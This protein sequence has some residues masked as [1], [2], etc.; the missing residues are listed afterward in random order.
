MRR[1]RLAFLVA[2]LSCG[3]LSSSSLP[4]MT[5]A[6]DL[7]GKTLKPAIGV[8][9]GMDSVIGSLLAGALT[10]DV[11]QAV[12]RKDEPTRITVT[13]S[14]TGFQGAKI[15][16]EITASD[17]KTQRQIHGSEPIA[18]QSTPGEVDLSFELDPNAADNTLVKSSYLKVCV[19]KADKST[20]S[21]VKAF[22]LAKTWQNG[23]RAEN[24]LVTITPKPI[25]TT[26]SLGIMPGTPPVPPKVIHIT[27]IRVST[28]MTPARSL[29]LATTPP[30]AASK[31]ASGGT[32]PVRSMMATRA[33][34][35][36]PAAGAGASPTPP[37]I[38]TA[39]AGAANTASPAIKLVPASTIA[40]SRFK[41]GVP[42]AGSTPNSP[43][44]PGDTPVE[45]MG[46]LRAED[47]D[48]D[49]S[50]V[51]GVFPAFYPDQNPASGVFYFLPYSY[52][53]RWSEDSGYDLKMIYSS[54]NGGGSGDVAMAARLDAGLG[55]RD[56]QIA[57]DLMQAYAQT[58]GLAFTALRALPIDS[59]GVSIADD[60]HRYNIPRDK[61]AVTG[62]SDF[63]GQIDI[64]W[65]TDP[66]TK[67]NLQQ[68]LVE[69]VG[70]SGKVTLYPS[71]GKLAP[72]DVPVQIRLA[73]FVTFGGFKWNR[74]EPWKNR[75]LYPIRLKYLNA[76]VL[77]ASSH[78]IVYSWDLSS[79][80]V[81]P[82]GRA[83]WVAGSVPTWIDA[84]AKRIW[85]E[86]AVDGSCESCAD[87]VIQSI[88]GGTTSAGPSTV[89][90]HTI[91]PLAD[92]GAF[93]IDAQVRSRY[94]DPQGNQLQTRTVVLNADG[95]DFTIGPLYL[96][97]RQP[98]ESV[99]G[100]P[101]F[102]YSLSVVKQD[103]THS[104]GSTWLSCNDLRLVIG[105]RQLEDALGALP[106]K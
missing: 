19:A 71:G 62:L 86:Y 58:H 75:T 63:L 27:P 97:N 37:P 39:S 45:P 11:T 88:T 59:I 7:A 106:T 100:D 77:D 81:P 64:S 31:S 60:L 90:L 82:S 92:A 24:V 43:K 35:S 44:G 15:W 72:V 23:T 66:V 41:F 40:I 16:G 13:V 4:A 2:L 5:R 34:L 76:L 22:D 85:L 55:I 94:F 87:A 68:A 38:R 10:G 98:G 65:L 47:I 105:R 54:A 20:A 28:V 70:I 50:H 67:E 9:F 26:A 69:G 56:R 21:F 96:G 93:E 78:P 91:T 104:D 29:T 49:A 99:P 61:I 36:T 73:D 6:A 25:G 52:S 33:I 1:N 51:L 17:R 48:L 53:L 89:T 30:Q 80:M 101:L 102:E 79:T 57:S 42:D 74:A 83:Q 8:K 14:Y 46:D 103:G 12:V 95:K 84:Q 3:T 18:I 32:T